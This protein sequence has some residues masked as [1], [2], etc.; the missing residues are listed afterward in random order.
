M[1]SSPSAKTEK[2]E[3]STE[4]TD[5]KRTVRFAFWKLLNQKPR[6]S[7]SWRG[8]LL[9]IGLTTCCSIFFVLRIHPFLSVTERE[10]TKIL[11][12]EGWIKEFAI[13][14]AVEEFNRGSYDKAFT[15]GGPVSGL[16]GY[17]SDYS[18]AASIGAGKLKSAGLSPDV[19]Q[20]VPSRVW[21]R[22]RTYSSAV[23]L[24]T[25][26]SEHGGVP[27]TINV[28]TEDL[29]ARRTRL[30]FQEAFGKETRVGIIAVQNP[31]YDPARW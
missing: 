12:V 6:W 31:D 18:T 15:T 5:S 21:G 2:K 4:S 14:A 3:V 8:W 1:S 26:F 30:L 16:G 22:D 20:M 9:L 7:L 19:V 13:K 23:A 11:V 24:R 27:Q 17:I 10:S 25:W 29:H 28:L